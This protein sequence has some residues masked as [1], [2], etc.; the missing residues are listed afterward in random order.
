LRKLILTLVL[1]ALAVPAA[2]QAPRHTPTKLPPPHAIGAAGKR[3]AAAADALMDM[4]VGPVI[5]AIEPGRRHRPTRLGDIAYRHD[6]YGR[7]RL[8]RSIERGSARAEAAARQLE[9]MAPRLLATFADARQRLKAALHGPIDDGYD[10]PV[11]RDPR[12]APPFER[13]APG[14]YQAAPD[15]GPAPGFDRAKPPFERVDPAA[16]GD[17]P[18]APEDRPDS[19][20]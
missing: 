4:D 9:I 2:A 15:E 11:A 16:P 1:T 20:D 3:A 13:V 8:H 19:D 5:D 10:A 6:P 7:E 17:Y 12:N 14:E 18:P